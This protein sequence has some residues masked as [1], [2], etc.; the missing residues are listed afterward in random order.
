MST[1]KIKP[2]PDSSD[3]STK[4]TTWLSHRKNGAYWVLVFVV[5]SAFYGLTAQTTIPWQ[6]SARFQWRILTQ[7]YFWLDGV[8]ANAHPL[9][10]VIGQIVKNIPIGDLF[11]RL[12][13]ISGLGMAA[14]LANFM[15]VVMLLTNRRWVALLFTAMFGLSHM[16]WWLAT[17]TQT[18]PLNLTWMTLQLLLLIKLIRD[19][20][21]QRLAIL[22][23][24][25]GVNLSL[26]GLALLMIPVEGLLVL[27][28]IFIKRELPL[29]SLGVAAATYCTGAVL[30]IVLVIKS[31]MSTGSLRFALF[32]AFFGVGYD[33]VTNTKFLTEFTI[34][35]AAIAS[36]S[37]M[38]V[39]L[40]LAIVGWIKFRKL[41]GNTTAIVL[42]AITLID[43]IF[44]VRLKAI[45]IFI[46]CLPAMTMIALAAAVGANYLIQLSIGWRRAV[47]I[48]SMASIV[49]MPIIYGVLPDVLRGFGIEVNRPRMLPFRDEMRY[50]ITPWKQ[51]ENSAQKF[52]EAAFREAGPNGVI[53]S[54]Q[55]PFSVLLLARSE[56]QSFQGVGIR[57]NSFGRV[58]WPGSPL[59]SYNSSP[60]EFRA[61]L[62]DRQLYVVSPIFIDEVDL[63]IER[64]AEISKGV[65]D[66]L[67]RVYWKNGSLGKKK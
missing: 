41:L 46:F 53:I 4:F 22:A 13:W 31:A 15:A 48:S 43:I 38:N 2:S 54:D 61:L 26:H 45:M 59:P 33:M 63:G 47:I 5:A 39:L 10:I 24:V 60:S 25:A 66:V 28:L 58:K 11:W 30:F 20:R 17:I 19:P 27:Y 1:L 62:G 42:G 29:W 37:F 34:P 64:D 14:A 67:Y 18:Y 32:D 50:W 7:D 21:W 36:L 56:N 35:N 23:F 57:G 9:L 49:G 40:P 51:N 12:N 6:D 55:T 44:V 8:G 3:V 52:A 16:I 65:N